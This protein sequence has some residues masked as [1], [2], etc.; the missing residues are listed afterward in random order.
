MK[1]LWLLITALAS[2]GL[3]A[4]SF[5]DFNPK[6]LKLPFGVN[7]ISNN[8]SITLA[9]DLEDKNLTSEGLIIKINGVQ[10]V[11]LKSQD[12][13]ILPLGP[14]SYKLST[15]ANGS[16]EKVT[17]ITI[18]ENTHRKIFYKALDIHKQ[19]QDIVFGI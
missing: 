14:G 17:P 5:S 12:Y 1:F 16:K 10:I 18:K 11:T 8:S 15:Y 2:L 9:Y 4:V 6:T 13:I 7:S 3:S 19:K